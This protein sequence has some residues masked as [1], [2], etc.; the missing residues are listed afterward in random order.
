MNLFG[1]CIIKMYL[2]TNLTH[3][4]TCSCHGHPSYDIFGF[5]DEGVDVSFNLIHFFNHW[6]ALTHSLTQYLCYQTVSLGSCFST[7]CPGMINAR[8]E[9]NSILELELM[10]NSGIGIAYLNKNEIGIEVCYKKNSSR[11]P[12]S[13]KPIIRSGWL[14]TKWWMT[15]N[16]LQH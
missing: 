14:H 3:T 9:V 11:V 5:C 4:H 2:F 15:W 1:Q 7:R 10:S 13:N 12:T 16:W 8:H 6:L